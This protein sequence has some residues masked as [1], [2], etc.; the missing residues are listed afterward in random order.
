MREAEPANPAARA[1][2]AATTT[3]VAPLRM[4]I[5]RI[6]AA[7]MHWN[8]WTAGNLRPA[9]AS[10][11]AHELNVR[12]RRRTKQVTRSAAERMFATGR[13]GHID[14]HEGIRSRRGWPAAGK[15]TVAHALALEMGL[16]FCQKTR[17][18]KP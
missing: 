13:S 15:T 5:R 16:A 14:S 4:A 8:L 9:P 17:L 18:R 2:E 7:P 1:T 11:P 3:E 10:R 6:Q 12:Q